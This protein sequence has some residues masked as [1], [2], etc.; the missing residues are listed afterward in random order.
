MDMDN[1]NTHL[2]EYVK[3]SPVSVGKLAGKIGLRREGSRDS[4]TALK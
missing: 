2:S 4:L 3:K 1:I